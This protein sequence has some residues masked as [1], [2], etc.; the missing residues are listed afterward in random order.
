MFFFNKFLV[1]WFL[2]IMEHFETSED[3]LPDTPLVTIFEKKEGG[4]V[5]GN[6]FRFW[7]ILHKPRFQISDLEKN[8][9]GLPGRISSGM[10]C[11]Q[12]FK[13]K[14]NKICKIVFNVCSWLSTTESF[15]EISFGK[16][17]EQKFWF[18]FYFGPWWSVL[19]NWYV[20]ITSRKQN[21]KNSTF[22]VSAEQYWYCKNFIKYV[23]WYKNYWFKVVANTRV[24]HKWQR[25]MIITFFLFVMTF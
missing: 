17:Q 19:K 15:T 23:L 25:Q 22:L 10:W 24:T 18:F 13:K 3:I 7:E 21:I 14:W 8:K 5:S 16:K 9:G 6:I 2:H 1:S 4:G 12:I 11:F 20:S